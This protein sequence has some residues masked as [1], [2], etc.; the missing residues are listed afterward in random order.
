MVPAFSLAIELE[1]TLQQL[2]IEEVRDNPPL[3]RALKLHASG[4]DKWLELL[5]QAAQAAG[6]FPLYPTVEKEQL[7]LP[8]RLWKDELT[9]LQLQE[10]S[11]GQLLRLGALLAAYDLLIDYY[12]QAQAN[13]PH[14]ATKLFL[15]SGI[16]IKRLQKAAVEKLFRLASH[17]VWGR[18]GFS[19]VS[20]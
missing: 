13:E 6:A 16:E 18:V 15:S 10:L 14:P 2:L 12:R 19:P 9:E 4:Q 3:A 17:Q 7:L 11:S 1:A 8:E 20:R 5:R